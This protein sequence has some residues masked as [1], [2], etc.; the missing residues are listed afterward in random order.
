MSRH[1][2]LFPTHRDRSMLIDGHRGRLPILLVQFDRCAER[3]ATIKR[4]ADHHFSP[5]RRLFLPHYDNSPRWIDRHLWMVG[6][7]PL[8]TIQ[9]FFGGKTLSL[10]VRVGQI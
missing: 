2:M 9:L 6:E 7:S 8:G 1:C 3:L 5:D 4:I 10:V